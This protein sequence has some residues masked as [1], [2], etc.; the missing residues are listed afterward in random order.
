M[1]KILIISGYAYPTQAP[2]SFRTSELAEQLIRMGH[3]VTVY[4][5]LGNYDYCSYEKET[6]VTMKDIPSFLSLP[7]PNQE[8]ERNIVTK[9]LW[10]LLSRWVMIPDIEYV[11]RVNKILKKEHDI[12][13]LITIAAPHM[14]H[15]GAARFKKHNQKAFP[16]VWIADSGDPCFLNPMHHFPGK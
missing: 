6:G 9:I 3:S 5:P 15:I 10:R 1:L 2:R 16:L 8:G 12:D 11:Y 14:I 4:S 13:L 7:R